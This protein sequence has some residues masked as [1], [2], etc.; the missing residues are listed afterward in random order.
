MFLSYKCLVCSS[1][2]ERDGKASPTSF[3]VCQTNLVMFRPYEASRSG[4]YRLNWDNIRA[5]LSETEAGDLKKEGG[6]T[7]L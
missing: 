6:I 3:V 5:H 7:Y 2:G 1:D 4:C